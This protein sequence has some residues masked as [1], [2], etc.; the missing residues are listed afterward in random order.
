[1]KKLK[2]IIILFIVLFT[3]IA[4]APRF[5]TPYIEDTI[6]TYLKETDDL[7]ADFGELR[8]SFLTQSIVLENFSLK[9]PDLSD[10]NTLLKASQVEFKVRL[11]PLFKKQFEISKIKINR[12]KITFHT[13]LKD[14]TNWD[15]FLKRERPPLPLMC[16]KILIENGTFYYL[17]EIS[18]NVTASAEFKGIFI[19][20]RNSSTPI[21]KMHGTPLFTRIKARGYIPTKPKGYISFEAKLNLV[22][23]KKSFR[24]NVSM[25]DISIT[26]FNKFRPQDTP[27]YPTDG[28]FSLKSLMTICLLLHSDGATKITLPAFLRSA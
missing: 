15:Y 14:T 25:K 18:N 23:E 26:Y 7:P 13:T 27:V 17:Q 11:L 5:L 24:G 2:Y 21:A 22:N 9:N 4:L 19:Y 3:A 28:S 8:V 20:I 1:M 10:N 16:N 6:R 12:P